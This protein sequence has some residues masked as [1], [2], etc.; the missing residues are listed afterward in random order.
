MKE[1]LFHTF[2]KLFMSRKG[3]AFCACFF[4]NIYCTI[5]STIYALSGNENIAYCLVGMAVFYMLCE[6]IILRIIQID[7]IQV[8]IKK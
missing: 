3:L 1:A 8:S 4:L 5:Y 7:K 6:L 2:K